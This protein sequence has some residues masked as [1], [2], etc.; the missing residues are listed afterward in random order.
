MRSLLFG[1]TAEYEQCSVAVWTLGMPVR[2]IQSAARA[3]YAHR[4]L[5]SLGMFLN[6][7]RFSGALSCLP[8]AA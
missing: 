7:K 1:W 4:G 2:A 3:L 8:S 5:Y 6:G